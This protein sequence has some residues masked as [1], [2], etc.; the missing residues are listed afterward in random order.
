MPPRAARP[1]RAA[2]PLRRLGVC[3]VLVVLAFSLLAFRVTQLQVLSGDHYEELALRQRLRTIPLNAER[4]NIFDRNGR[5]LAISVERSS[6]YAD[7]TL[8]A[9]PALY[10]SK[11]APIVAVDQQMLY[12]RLADK[13]RRFVYIA[14]TVD[15]A[16]AAA[17]RELA[18]PGV[19][20]VPEAQRQYPAGS[21]ASALIGRVGGEGYGLDGLEAHY[22]EVLKGS[23]GEVVV[24]RDQRGREIPNTE[25]KRVDAR[26]GNDLV[27]TIDE[28]IQYQVEQTLTDQVTAT[29]AK[30]GMAVMVDV[31]SGDVVAMATVQGPAN[32]EP[33]HAARAGESTN[34]PLT[35]LFEPGSTNKLITVA[36]AIEQGR[37][38]AH[39]PFDVPAQIRVGDEK[40]YTDSHRENGRDRWSTTDIL[41]E[42]SNVGTILIAQ[43]LG[44]EALAQALRD[45]GFG[46]TTAIDY[47]GQPRGLLLHP[48]EYYTTG[49]ASTAIGYAIS[50]TAM[51]MVD[52][53]T[54]IANDGVSVPP[55]LLGATID[56][57]GERQVTATEPGAR[58]ISEKTAR[59]MTDMLGE[60]V[61]AGT[62]ACA[63]IPGYAVAGK[64]GTARKAAPEGGYSEATYASFVGFAPADDP[65]LAA[66]VVLDEPRNEFGSV[67]AAPVFSEIVRAALTQY[68]VP[69]T[70]VGPDSQFEAASAHAREQGSQCA[71]LHGDAL[72][73]H[74]AR[75]AQA[76]REAAADAAA[77]QAASSGTDA[78]PP[79]TVAGDSSPS[80]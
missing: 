76:A 53:Y 35:D 63:A 5:D 56:A 27:L 42:S 32:G 78:D 44:K 67:A 64:T 20:F 61:R 72:A 71:V 36:A 43:D 25:R 23:P 73:Q 10:A 19:A 50:V 40:T 69:P 59:T 14:R 52:V 2:K 54:T 6:V 49:L 66:I 58:V 11:L 1:A 22:D 75:Q 12:E 80:D 17:I 28:T 21:V 8:V 18:L 39:T 33:A 51:Q 29:G 45:F 4:G 9:D 24:E 13:S 34:R 46:A 26:P 55:R 48:D 79:G 62:G 70:D 65:R 41:R 15:D 68:R 38:G 77:N 7:P 31:R 60:V 74:L 30:G 47:P 3:T 16:T 57:D 37:I